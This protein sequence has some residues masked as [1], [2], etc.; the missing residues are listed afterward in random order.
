MS[1][2]YAPYWVT[3]EDSSGGCCD[4]L[5][6][7]DA[8]QRA[9]EITEKKVSEVDILPYPASPIIW[10]YKHP[11]YGSCPPFCWSPKTCQGYSSCPKNRE[12]SE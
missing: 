6:I 5:S 9:T 8:A 10:Q 7:S 1:E 3:F 11:E 4:G 12:C 2:H